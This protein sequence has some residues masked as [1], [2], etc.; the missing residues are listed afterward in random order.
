L[1]GVKELKSRDLSHLSEHNLIL[2]N[3]M[4]AGYNFPVSVKQLHLHM[5]VVPFFHD[6]VFIPPR[7]HSHRKV[8]NDLEKFGKVK[9]QTENDPTCQEEFKLIHEKVDK[10]TKLFE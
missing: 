8:L 9:L 6:K 2:E 3:A 10:L 5:T 1:L 4:F 7:W